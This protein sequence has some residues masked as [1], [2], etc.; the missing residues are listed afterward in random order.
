MQ[1]LY[2]SRNPFPWFIKW[3]I[4]V[5]GLTNQGGTGENRKYVNFHC[6]ISIVY[7]VQSQLQLSKVRFSGRNY[8]LLHYYEKTVK[9]NGN[10][11][12]WKRKKKNLTAHVYQ[13]ISGLHTLQLIF[14]R[15]SNGW[16]QVQ[17]RSVFQL[18]F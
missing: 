11:L 15:Y 9:I 5:L 2:G 7:L 1:R 8:F 3:I 18:Q 10:C 12:I 13:K 6:Q 14:I 17:L 16:S 4:F